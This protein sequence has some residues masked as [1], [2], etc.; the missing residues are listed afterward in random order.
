MLCLFYS[1][2]FVS[3]S[4]SARVI[5]AHVLLRTHSL[6]HTHTAHTH[7]HSLRSNFPWSLHCAHQ[8]NKAHESTTRTNNNSSSKSIGET[9]T[10]TTATQTFSTFKKLFI[11]FVVTQNRTLHQTF[12]FCVCVLLLLFITSL[13]YNLN[14]VDAKHQVSEII[15]WFCRIKC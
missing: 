14:I 6:T 12:I 8:T 13:V 1:S 4:S 5:E 11:L 9:T 2:S 15:F 3:T 10:T 7:T